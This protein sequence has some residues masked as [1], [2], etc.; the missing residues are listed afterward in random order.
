MKTVRSALIVMFFLFLLFALS[1]NIVDYRRNIKLHQT[2]KSEFEEEKK[3][4]IKL[5]T[6]ILRYNDPDE[7]EKTIRNKLNLV[8]DKEVAVIIAEPT[9]SAQRITPVPQQPFKQWLAVF[10]LMA[11]E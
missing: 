2:L 3:E 9:P 8:K 1:K 4:N 5:K 10:G 7:L 6:N 11:P